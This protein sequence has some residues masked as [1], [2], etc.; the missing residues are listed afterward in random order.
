MI[1]LR[2]AEPDL[3]RGFAPADASFA[4]RH[5]F[6]KGAGLEPSVQGGPAETGAVEHG[7]QPEDAVRFVS[8]DASLR[9]VWC[10]EV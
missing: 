9:R 3:D 7:L 8:H 1:E 2:I 5:L 4:D 6:G 10:R